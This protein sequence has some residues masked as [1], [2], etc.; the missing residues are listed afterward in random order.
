[1][2]GTF[3]ETSSGMRYFLC[4][5]FSCCFAD[6]RWERVNQSVFVPLFLGL[7]PLIESVIRFGAPVVRWKDV[8]GW[9]CQNRV[10]VFIIIIIMRK[11]QHGI[12]GKQP[13]THS[14]RDSTLMGRN[15]SSCLPLLNVDRGSY[16]VAQCIIMSS[17]P[18]LN[19]SPIIIIIYDNS[20]KTVTCHIVGHIEW[21]YREEQHPAASLSRAH[22][23]APPSSAAAALTVDTEDDVD[24]DY[25]AT[26]LKDWR[27]RVVVMRRRC[28]AANQVN[29]RIN[30]L[31][32]YGI[33]AS[34]GQPCTGGGLE[35]TPR[36]EWW[37]RCRFNRFENFTENWWQEQSRWQSNKWG[38]KFIILRINALV[39]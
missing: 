4:H 3:I 29:R 33:Y 11:W 10:E 38:C 12:T 17:C 22:N 36:G 1:M 26:K 15:D 28:V 35:E 19:R 7:P 32:K 16:W 30:K 39:N 2:I 25:S 14:A 20:G 31:L 6:I 18:L 9:L 37:I 13:L 27:L 24:D 5:R 21:L 23:L 34:F 8:L